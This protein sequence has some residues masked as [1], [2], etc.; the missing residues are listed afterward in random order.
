MSVS[1][2]PSVEEQRKLQDVAHAGAQ[3]AAT[4]PPE[5]ASD[6]DTLL[7]TAG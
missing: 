7:L 6:R 3:A 5:G 2:Q 4:G 1:D